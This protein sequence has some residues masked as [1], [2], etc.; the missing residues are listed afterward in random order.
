ML[1]GP[2]QGRLASGFCHWAPVGGDFRLQLGV[3]HSLGT[4]YF[5]QKAGACFL[6]LIGFQQIDPFLDAVDDRLDI[7]SDFTHEL[8]LIAVINEMVRQ[9]QAQH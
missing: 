8:G 3:E 5:F 7:K 9:A 4:L 1:W 2:N 6:G